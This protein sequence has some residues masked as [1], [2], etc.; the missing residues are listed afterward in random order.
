MNDNAVASLA[1]LVFLVAIDLGFAVYW[2]IIQIRN[3]LHRKR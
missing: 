1:L 2:I 3:K